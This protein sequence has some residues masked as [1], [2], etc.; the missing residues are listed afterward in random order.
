[1]NFKLEKQQFKAESKRL[2]DLMINS[3]YTNREIFLRELLSNASD[4]VSKLRFKSLTDDSIKSDF[5]IFIE[6]DKKNRTLSV[7]DDG[8]GMTRVELEQ[9]LGTIAQS[10]S[11]RFKNKNKEDALKII[12]QFGVGFYS[13]FMVA[14][15][16]TVETKALG[17][18]DAFLWESEGVDG[19]VIKLI[20]K[21][22]IGT[23]VTLTLKDNTEDENYDEFLDEFAIKNLVKKYSDYIE[24][25][26]KMECEHSKRK[27]GA[28]DGDKDAFETFKSVDTLNSM[29]PIWKKDKKSLKEEEINE[30]YKSK[31]FDFANPAKV[32]QFKTEGVSTY[33][34]MLF[35]PSTTP[36]NYYTKEYEKGLQ[37]YSN[38][39]LITEK[40]EEMLPDYFSFVKGIVDSQDIQ[41][42]ISRETLQKN[43]QVQII[44]KNIEKK[45]SN[46]LLSWQKNDRVA[47]EKFFKNFGAQLKYG[48]YANY[49]ANK[50]KLQ[51]L[52]LF[53]SSKMKAN[54]TL[55]EYVSRMQSEQAA[56]Y[57]ACGETVAQIDNMP[58]MEFVKVKGFEVLFLT[59]DIDEFAIKA[60]SEFEGKKFINITSS[61]LNFESDA[62]KQENEETAKKN[63]NLIKIIKEELKDKI[64]D[65]KISGR[66]K[67]CAVCLTTQGDISIE[68]EKVLNAMPSGQKV[69][70]QKILE[71]N[72]NHEIFKKLCELEKN[73]VSQ[74]KLY[75]NLLYAQAALIEGIVPK[76]P[77]DF[78][79]SLTK[80]MAR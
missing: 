61:E 41:L 31:F 11:L 79:N 23:K 74:L 56:I 6:I 32:I 10:D 27:E 58:Q 76:N 9:N 48:I 46:E 36:F 55:K 63:E 67:N 35:I 50:D 60:L 51:D 62:E 37:L 34:A 17:S 43:R 65:V 64:S 71:I 66:I 77:V 21:D 1:M 26:I 29:K 15:K 78:S 75:A 54:T 24:F 39:V 22:K 44:A 5:A 45:I 2:L 19:F 49:G 59:E 4:A 14:K 25:P 7:S 16:V 68:M 20:E 73:D 28:K 69:S 13:A 52:I 70:S 12:G 72:K 80:I 42:N 3:I 40:C 18:A 57:Y 33:N 38:G 53:Y 47:Y 30:F 8:I